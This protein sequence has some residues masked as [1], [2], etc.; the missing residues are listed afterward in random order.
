VASDPKFVVSMKKRCKYEKTKLLRL[1]FWVLNEL[2]Q[3]DSRVSTQHIH[4]PVDKLLIN[5]S[6]DCPWQSTCADRALIRADIIFF[7]S[8][9]AD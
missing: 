9:K 5:L 3:Y 1:L 4:A 7:T 8:V 6:T 2:C